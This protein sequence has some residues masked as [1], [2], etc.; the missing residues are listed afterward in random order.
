MVSPSSVWLEKSLAIKVAPFH[1]EFISK[2]VSIKRIPLQQL[3]VSDDEKI[4]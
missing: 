4:I 2:I 1:E 3:L